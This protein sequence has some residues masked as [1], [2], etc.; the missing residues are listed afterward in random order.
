MTHTLLRGWCCPKNE[1]WLKDARYLFNDYNKI[2]PFRQLYHLSFTIEKCLRTIAIGLTQK[3][4]SSTVNEHGDEEGTVKAW[5]S[6]MHWNQ[7]VTKRFIGRNCDVF[8]LVKKLKNAYLH[9][10]TQVNKKWLFIEIVNTMFMV[11]GLETSSDRKAWVEP[12]SSSTDC[13]KTTHGAEQSQ[14]QTRPPIPNTPNALCKHCTY[15]YVVFMYA[16]RLFSLV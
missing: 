12:D 1:W 10:N 5:I 13:L 2:M 9:I 7:K 11:K 16:M 15:V 6:W 3:F 8:H 4:S 14:Q